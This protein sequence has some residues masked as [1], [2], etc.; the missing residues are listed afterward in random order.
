VCFL[1]KGKI[2]KWHK[3]VGD[4]VNPDDILADVE[5]DKATVD[6]ALT[7]EGYLAK[8]LVPE[9]AADV[10][11][12]QVITIFYFHPKL[13]AV[14][15]DNKEDVAK[16]ADASADDIVGKTAPAPQTVSTQPSQQ[17]QSANVSRSS[18]PGI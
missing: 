16:F 7:D 12:G 10:P 14:V 4:K 1:L 15:V 13:V 8:L 2:A 18:S 17:S 5:T 9:G 6:F 11:V 3:K